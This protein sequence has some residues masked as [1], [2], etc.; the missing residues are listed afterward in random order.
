MYL[1]RA[2]ALANGATIAGVSA[3]QDLRML[4]EHRG[5]TAPAATVTNILTERRKEL[6]FEGHILYDLKRTGNGVVRTDDAGA[7]VPFP[8]NRWAFPIPK[9]ECD[10][11]PNMVQNP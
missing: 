1:N 2:E 4:C 5:I 9:S 8:D 3:D 11:N 6:A 10:A 7:N